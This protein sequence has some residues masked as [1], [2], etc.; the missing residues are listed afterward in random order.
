MD[1]PDRVIELITDKY[2]ASLDMNNL[3]PRKQRAGELYFHMESQF[4]TENAGRASIKAQKLKCPG[5]IT[6]NQ[7]ARLIAATEN[8]KCIKCVED[9]G[10]SEYDLLGVYQETGTSAGTYSTEDVA[11]YRLI[12]E[13]NQEVNIN[14]LKNI[15]SRL[16]ELVP[17]V[18]RC[19]EPDI[20]A[21]NNGLFDFKTKQLMPFSPDKVFL[22]KSKINYNPNATN[23]I[24]HNPVD[25][26]DWDIESWIMELA[27]NNQEIANLI[28]EIMSAIC[29]PNIRWNKAAF[30]YSTTG[31]NG[32]GTLCVLM[33]N[34]VGAGS[35]ANIPLTDF[36]KEF[37]LEPL[38]HA[39]CIIVDENDVGGYIDKAG[40]LK[41]VITGDTIMMNRKFKVPITYQFHGFMVQCINEMPRIRDRSNSFYRRQLF[42]PFKR[43]FTGAERPEIKNDYLNRTEV[44][45]YALHK[46]LHMT[47]YQLS[48]PDD[49]KIAIK[50]YKLANDPLREFCD[51]IIPQLV[52]DLAPFE[53]LY[54]LYKSWFSKKMAAGTPLGYTTFIRGLIEIINEE[55]PTW[56][57]P[58]KDSNGRHVKITGNDKMNNPELLIAKYDLATWKNRNYTAGMDINKMCTY[59][60]G[61]ER[62]T[63]LVR[64][65][66]VAS[67]DT[68][69]N[70]EETQ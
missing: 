3:P 65:T 12:H 42:V 17:H 29:R 8:V 39:T 2:I 61:S 16:R 57:Y 50:E 40:N 38:I 49:C 26:T 52:W 33:R 69:Q 21:V 4:Q 36:S 44:L 19:H 63:G 13:Y 34:L 59:H 25:N 62:F 15:T 24:I 5:R 11:I 1:A 53:F 27:D 18:D 14:S 51:D 37:N 70:K 20:I 56:V 22:A 54:D 68:T 7:I 31:N 64:A 23:P 66:I 45:E 30:F 43:C 47:H 41:A 46:V 10:D 28:W 32:K 60:P 67:I 48:E 58:G 55:Y 6:D 9:A 35:C